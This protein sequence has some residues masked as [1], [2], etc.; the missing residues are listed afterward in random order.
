MTDRDFN[1][2]QD[3]E[4]IDD[5]LPQSDHEVSAGSF[6]VVAYTMSTS[7]KGGNWYLNTNIQFVI[8]HSQGIQ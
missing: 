3:L 5:V 7:K 2:A 6:A 8:V 1:Y 4:N